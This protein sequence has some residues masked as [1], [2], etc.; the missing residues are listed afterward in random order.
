MCLTAIQAG[1]VQRRMVAKSHPGPRASV[2]VEYLPAVQVGGDFAWTRWSG[3]DRLY[4]AV[5]D[6]SGHG[7][8]SSLVASRVAPE[9]ERMFEQGEDLAA[10]AQRL[11]RLVWAMFV[12]ERVY[13]TLICALLDFGEGEV[14]YVNC[15]HPPALRWSR[16]SGAFATLPGEHCPVGL[17]DPEIFGRPRTKSAAIEAGDRLVLYTDGVLQLRAA[18]GAELGEAGLREAVQSLPERLD[19]EAPQQLF[20][21]LRALHEAHPADDLLLMLIDLHGGAG[22][23]HRA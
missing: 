6:V 10:F 20:A 11:N 16:R 8:T 3:E 2:F 12:E 18:D 14:R 19:E 1:A 9:V 15:G 5:A 17:F 4:A 23:P 13:L 7:I 22:R 21:R